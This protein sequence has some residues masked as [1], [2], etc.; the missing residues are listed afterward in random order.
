[1]I[2]IPPAIDT[3]WWSG[4]PN[5]GDAL[6]PYLFPRYGINVR[7][8][9]LPEASLVGVGSILKNIHK[10]PYA[11][12][13]GSGF[14]AARQSFALPR[15]R[16]FMVRGPLS[17]ER[18]GLAGE[19]VPLG[20]PG[21]LVKTP[22]DVPIR[23]AVGIVPHYADKG[24][25][26]VAALEARLAGE[27]SVI[28]VEHHDVDKFLAALAACEV[29][30]S[31]SLHGIILAWAIGKP[32]AWLELSD[33]VVGKGFKFRDFFSA[34]GTDMTPHCL[35]GHESCTDL[36]ARCVMPPDAIAM[37]KDDLA[38]GFAEARASLYSWRGR[39]KRYVSGIGLRGCRK[40]DDAP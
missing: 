12:V 34:A 13:M 7:Q 11:K 24:N 31:S 26:A 29:V 36:Q 19:A 5:V 15:E 32:A 16:V 40:L 2:G 1:M 9:P 23:Y 28:D 3:F 30:L 20:D 35:T 17:L 38:A 6:T 8:V 4:H 22:K 27:V 14:I 33:K 39:L 21:I 10:A 18:L 25:A 37:M